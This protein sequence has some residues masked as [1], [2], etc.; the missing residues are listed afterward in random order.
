MA[1]HS[2]ESKVDHLPETPAVPRA[3]AWLV[4]ALSFGLLLSDY[5]S[6]QV[7]NAV[8]PSLKLEW[9]LSDT[10]LG[11]LSGAV[12]LT[13]GLLAIPL[14]LLADRLGRVRSLT[15]M[16]TLWSVATLGCALSADF[17]EMLVAR[18]VVGVGEAA[19]GSVG[20]A[21]VLSVFP[22]HQWASLS[23]AFAAGGAFGA[24]LGMAL[25]GHVAARLGWRWS[26]GV[27][28]LFGLVLAAI[29]RFAI[30]EQ[31]LRPALEEGQHAAVARPPARQPM[32]LRSVLKALFP[33]LSIVCVYVGSGLHLFVMGAVLTWMPSYLNRY[34][35][36]T[37]DRA[38]AAAAVFVLIGGAGMIAC[39]VLTDRLSRG[40]PA[41]P[42]RMA[43][44]YSLTC[45]TLLGV[46]FRLEAGPMQLVLIGAGTLFAGG[47]AGPASAMVASMIR[48]SIRATAFAT[49]GLANNLL[50]MALAPLVTGVLA[51]RFGLLGALQV[52]PLVALAA[53]LAFALGG[54]HDGARRHAGAAVLQ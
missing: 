48:A 23:G 12:A 53:A 14:S 19:Y 41:R 36:M 44:A 29:Y 4:F 35:G 6:R 43:L 28:A 13:V 39:G 38:G 32:T 18:F 9:G 34:Y 5:M 25:G 27:M 42:W 33:T 22:R 45:C 8:F 40:Q 21:V 3:Y 46:A 51:D 20:I 11:A 24:V 15:L 50:G 2:H 10:E 17:G 47:T 54:Q 52:A 30:T 1:P 37:V 31:R 16:A 49:L 26:F 7:L